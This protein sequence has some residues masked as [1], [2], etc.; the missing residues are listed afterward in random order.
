MQVTE[1]HEPIAEGGPPLRY[2]VRIWRPIPGYVD[3]AEDWDVAEAEDIIE[4]MD[5][6][7]KTARVHRFDVF[8]YAEW[9]GIDANT[10]QLVRSPELIRVFGEGQDGV[11]ETV[12]LY[13]D[14]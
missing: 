2:R 13:S 8:V 5:W 4:V 7:R 6:A 10:G 12:Y 14:G 11:T 1:A 9:A 3:A